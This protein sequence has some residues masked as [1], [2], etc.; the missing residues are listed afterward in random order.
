MS[1][2]FSLG[3]MITYN[4]HISDLSSDRFIANLIKLESIVDPDIP[5]IILLWIVDFPDE[6]FDLKIFFILRK[7]CQSVHCSQL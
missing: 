1:N 3:I 2:S 5:I 4:K 6:L 7:F